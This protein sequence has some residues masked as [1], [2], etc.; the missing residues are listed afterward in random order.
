M[1]GVKPMAKRPGSTADSV[2]IMKL[3]PFP[4]WKFL[5][6]S[7]E[8]PTPKTRSCPDSAYNVRNYTT[9]VEECGEF[10]IGGEEFWSASLFEPCQRLSCN[11][12]RRR[13]AADLPAIRQFHW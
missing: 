5:G 9:A 7:G 10:V 6:C 3:S 2:V 8:R 4:A 13:V 11:S 12:S 1:V